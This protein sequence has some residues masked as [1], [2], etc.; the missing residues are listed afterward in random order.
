MVSRSHHEVYLP[1]LYID[2]F[3]ITI[4][5]PLALIVFAVALERGVIRAGRQMVERLFSLIT[6]DRGIGASAI[7][8]SRHSRAP[9]GAV[10]LGVA[11]V[12][13]LGIRV[14][15]FLL[16]ETGSG[17]QRVD[18]QPL[19]I[20]EHPS[21]IHIGRLEIESADELQEAS[22]ART[23]NQS[24]RRRIEEWLSGSIRGDGQTTVWRREIGVV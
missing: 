6:F 7:E 23:R 11:S 24:I 2:F 10:D 5:L 15:G 18:K 22:L 19:R 3:A 9:I 20:A 14:A 16:R 8:G 13:Q 21:K 1:F 17:Y 4:E 12:T